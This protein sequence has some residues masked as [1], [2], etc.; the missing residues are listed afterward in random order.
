[1]T[2]STDPWDLPIRSD[3]IELIRL[4]RSVLDAVTSG[5]DTVPGHWEACTR[6]PIPEHARRARGRIE[7]PGVSVRVD[8][9]SD[10]VARFFLAVRGQD[11]DTDS[12]PPTSL[13]SRESAAPA[14][15]PPPAVQ[16]PAEILSA[17]RTEAAMNRSAQYTE[18][19]GRLIERVLIWCQKSDPFSLTREDIAGFITQMRDKGWPKELANKIKSPKGKSHAGRPVHPNTLRVYATRIETFFDWAVQTERLKASPIVGLQKP[20]TID[21]EQRAFNDDEVRRIIAAARADEESPHPK[22]PTKR[23]RLY[24]FLAITGCAIAMSEILRWKDFDLEA[25]TPVVK[26]FRSKTKKEWE[27]SLDDDTAAMLRAWRDEQKAEPRDLVFGKRPNDRCVYRDMEDAG[28]DRKDKH[29]RSGCWHLFRR[30][31]GTQLALAGVDP[32]VAQKRLGHKN[33]TTTLKHYN[34]ADENKLAQAAAASSLADV[35]NLASLKDSSATCRRSDDGVDSRIPHRSS[36]QMQETLQIQAEKRGRSP[37]LRCG[38]QYAHLARP[39][40]GA[41][42]RVSS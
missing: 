29:G 5:V 20:S 3:N 10:A 16:T 25:D 7:A 38:N 42:C 36:S 17:F 11:H 24:H 6:F 27:I 4:D 30:F 37:A 32:K 8:G 15:T 14:R 2:D 23:W 35:L 41:G 21:K 13:R 1:M 22:R 33:V 39:Q 18:E 9:E 26:V 12:M 40:A 31:V 28:I 19:C 34:R